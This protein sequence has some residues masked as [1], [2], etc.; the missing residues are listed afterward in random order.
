MEKRLSAKLLVFALLLVPSSGFGWGHEGHTVV[1]L[2]AERYMM[3]EALAR[4]GN[5]LDGAAIDSVGSWADDYRHD[6]PE[7]GPWHYID[8]PLAD[9]KIDMA[10]ACP[11]GN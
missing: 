1:G 11:N 10:R 3:G 4:A 2:I 8:I 9:S 6:H 5:L 7:T